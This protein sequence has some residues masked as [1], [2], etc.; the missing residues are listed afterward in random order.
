MRNESIR[1]VL[2]RNGA[3]YGILHPAKNSAPTLRTSSK[4]PIKA[5]LQGEFLPEAYDPTGKQVAVDW[6]NDEIKPVLIIDGEES[7]L[8]IF[9]PT[10]R[11]TVNGRDGKSV[12]IEAYDRCW[13]VQS[14]LKENVAYFPSGMRYLDAVGAL[15]TQAGITTVAV[16][17]T[18][19][20]LQEAREDWDVGTSNLAIA[21]QLL[22]EIN[23]KQLW[24]DARGTAVLEPESVP[25]AENIQHILTE[26]KPDPRN[27]KE[28][29][30]ISVM[31][32]VN[33]S[34]DVFSEPNV[35]ICICSNPDKAAGLVAIAE[36]AN[37]Q[38]PLSIQSRGRR[39]AS[40]E[41]VD[42]IASQA[43]LQMYANQ[44][45]SRSL[46]TGEI[47]DAK[48]RLQPDFGIGDITGLQ[49]DD[50]LSVCVERE[51]TMELKPG[52]T[53]THKL[54]KVVLNIAE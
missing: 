8:G 33:R 29:G 15:L 2:L 10:T 3:D 16:T 25:T 30:L 34:T 13:R 49:Y 17:E 27:P 36:N 1:F 12:Q 31:P 21:N 23:Y 42:N 41:R 46:M 7:P 50:I 18:E 43:E 11:T 44:K 45:A 47:I 4:G 38:S 14:T 6:L 5:S 40:V 24:F 32:E 35:F 28:I 26:R 48:T 51:W 52:G 9:S 22:A 39:I 19:A 54:E 20:T 53:M 37:P